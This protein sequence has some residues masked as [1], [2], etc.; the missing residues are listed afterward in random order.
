MAYPYR[1][2]VVTGGAGFL[3]SYVVERL[4]DRGWQVIVPRSEDYDLR[5]MAA[6][7]QL[8]ADAQP[9]CIIHLAA[10]CG[11]IGANR[12]NPGS[13]FYDNL[14]MG[15]HLMEAAR[16]LGVKKFVAVGSVCSYPKYTPVPFKEEWLWQGYPEET[17]APY[18][19]AK[20][21]LLVQSQAYRQQYGLNSIYLIPAN[22]YGPRDNFNLDTS[23]VIPA[24][25]AKCAEA[26]SDVVCWG[27]GTPTREFL[28]ADD[29]ARGII[30]AMEHYNEPE[31]VNLG[32]G[33]EI[34]ICNLADKI[35]RLTGLRHRLLWDS[36]QPDGQPLRRLDTSRAEQFGFR[37]SIGLDDGLKQTVKW[38]RDNVQLKQAAA[39]V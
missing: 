38:Y 37:A 7:R 19:L 6:V 5:D 26:D 12:A 36:S 20:K 10:T 24:L 28:H 17:N 35:A 1:Q 15:A 8:Y 22:L 23:H 16:Q 14:V 39:G 30:L 21:M 3:G 32:S 9:D 18:A 33:Q 34:S 31:P 25:I 27:T 29:A 4:R 2:I 13:Y 11:G